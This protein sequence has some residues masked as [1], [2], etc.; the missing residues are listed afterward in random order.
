MACLILESCVTIRRIG[1]GDWFVF[2]TTG[3]TCY[4]LI[5]A[6]QS[7]GSLE[8]LSADNADFVLPVQK[9]WCVLRSMHPTVN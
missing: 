6:L 4:V 3:F 1:D 9:V 7:R 8:S 5:C 2:V